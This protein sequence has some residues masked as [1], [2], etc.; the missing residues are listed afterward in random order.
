MDYRPTPDQRSTLELLRYLSYCAIG[1]A[2][3][4]A[5]GSWDAYREYAQA[6]AEM[7]ADEFPAAMERQRE[8]LRTFFGGLTQEQVETQMATTPVGEEMPLEKALV[9]LPL[10]WM[11]AYRMQLFLYCKQAGNEEIWTP[12]CWV[13]SDME[14]PTP[15]EAPADEAST[16]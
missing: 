15:Q 14:K 10:H 11:V 9:L 6:G 13:G 3:A 1:G 16:S 2:R 12:N 8:E 7:G 5:D 4:M